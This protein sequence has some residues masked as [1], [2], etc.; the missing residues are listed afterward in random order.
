MAR[1]Q[2]REEFDRRVREKTDEGMRAEQD[3]LLAIK[4]KEE[5]E[6]KALRQQMLFKAS[7]IRHFRFKMR[8]GAEVAPR[9]ITVPQAPKLQTQERAHLKDNEC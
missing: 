4:L 6:V 7:K 5:E 9:A 3:R 1:S 2:Q 8:E